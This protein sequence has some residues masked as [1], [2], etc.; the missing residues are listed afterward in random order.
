M[1]SYPEVILAAR[2]VEMEAANTRSPT[3][4]STG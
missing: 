1:G 3:P 4:C 2:A